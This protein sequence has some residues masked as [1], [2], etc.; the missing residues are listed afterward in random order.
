MRFSY[1]LKSLKIKPEALQ[2]IAYRAFFEPS[3]GRQFMA[4]LGAGIAAGIL[5]T[6]V[7]ILLWS[8]FTESWVDRLLRD[9]RLTAA[10]VMGQ[11]VL[12]PAQGFDAPVM[13][14]ATLLHFALSVLY[15]AVLSLLIRSNLGM[16]LWIGWI[17]GLGLFFLNLYGFT[18][19]FPWFAQARDWIT[20]IAHLVFGVTAAATYQHLDTFPSPSKN[21]DEK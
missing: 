7:Q 20:F 19:L 15:A 21:G 8:M 12:P 10:L 16:S 11:T 17:F 14:I 1:V 3:T 4:V 6:A 18:L 5:A 13:V 9:V 2:G